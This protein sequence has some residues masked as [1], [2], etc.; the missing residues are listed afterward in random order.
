MFF[1]C[2]SFITF[3]ID[4][5]PSS[6]CSAMQRSH[7]SSKR[8]I[9]SAKR[10]FTLMKHAFPLSGTLCKMSSLTF[11]KLWMWS[12]TAD[13]FACFRSKSPNVSINST[14]FLFRCSFM[15][16]KSTRAILQY[17]L[18]SCNAQLNGYSIRILLFHL[19]TYGKAEYEN[20]KQ[21]CELL[22]CKFQ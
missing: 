18:L 5:L 10:Y 11:F 12:K 7:N 1:D 14:K 8:R 20:G 17:P 9:D 6:E 13:T 2:A 3:K 15:S 4:V 19:N 21:K 22:H 16:S